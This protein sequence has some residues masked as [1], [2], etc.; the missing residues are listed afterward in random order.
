MSN[1]EA[2][3][4]GGVSC[5]IEIQLFSCCFLLLTGC[6][7]PGPAAVPQPYQ[8]QSSIQVD[9]KDAVTELTQWMMES[10]KI[11]DPV[12]DWTVDGYD[13][14]M[15]VNQELSVP[16][17]GL[18]CLRGRQVAEWI[19]QKWSVELGRRADGFTMRDDSGHILLRNRPRVFGGTEYHCGMD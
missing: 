13:L 12:L 16:M 3:R 1:Q 19:Y 10:W 14:D 5:R 15:Y 7:E 4:K 17:R 6:T 11:P 8:N 2:A 18:D 9:P